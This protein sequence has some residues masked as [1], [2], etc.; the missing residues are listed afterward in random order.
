[1]K[2]KSL[3]IILVSMLVSMKLMAA[4]IIVGTGTSSAYR[5]PYYTFF[6]Y[7]TQEYIYKASEIG[8]AGTINGISF[9]VNA[10]KSQTA[11]IKV[12]LGHTSLNSLSNQMTSGMT[13]VY[14]SSRT[15]GSSTGWEYLSFSTPFNYNGNDN[16]VVIV[17][18]SCSSYDSNLTYRY[19]SGQSTS[20]YRY[21][22]T[23]TD[24][25][26]WN[27]SGGFS[28]TTDRPNIRFDIPNDVKGLKIINT[29]FDFTVNNIYYKVESLNDL[30]C[31]VA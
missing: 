27:Y 24:Y 4:Y 6:K 9:Y 1:M 2:I 22:D 14:N 5:Y 7:S 15:I 17:T 3:S 23:I 29:D 11:T 16:L 8:G 30:T 28:T 18:K 26:T 10:A 31:K 19:T 13:C 21:S 20:L 12:Y 25:A